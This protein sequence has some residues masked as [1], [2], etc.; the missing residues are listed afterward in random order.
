[1]GLGWDGLN[2]RPGGVMM[3]ICY[4]II[5]PALGGNCHLIMLSPVYV[6]LLHLNMCSEINHFHLIRKV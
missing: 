1:M 6:A 2:L 5:L 3:L 4:A